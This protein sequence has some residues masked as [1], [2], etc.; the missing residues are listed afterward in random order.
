VHSP[1]VIHTQLTETKLARFTNGTRKDLFIRDRDLRGF[2]VAHA[3]G[4]GSDWLPVSD[5]TPDVLAEFVERLASTTP[6]PEQPPR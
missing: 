3:S 4:D 2:N 1:S 6:P 5:V